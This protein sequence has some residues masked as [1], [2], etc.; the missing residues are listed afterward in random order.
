MSPP[1][2]PE[3]VLPRLRRRLTAVFALVAA[4]GLAAFVVVLVAADA[5]AERRRV[6][7]DL[8]GA[9]SRAAALVY[10]ED[11]DPRTDGVA[12][13][14][15][16][17]APRSVLVLAAAPGG[18]TRTLLSV[19][20]LDPAAVGG[21]VAAGLADAAEEGS[22]ASVRSA[23]RTLRAAAMPWFVGPQDGD[24]AERVAGVAVVAV[25]PP[26]VDAGRLLV[27]GLAGGLALLALLVAAGWTLAGRSLRPAQAALAD[28]E[29]F[30]A[31]AAHELR[32]PLARLRAGA[33]AA[34]RASAG[35]ADPASELRGLVRTADDAA[36]VVA[37]LLLAARIDHAAVVV[38]RQP[39]RLDELAGELELH[40]PQVVA[41]VTG[42]VTVTG[43]AGLLRHAL[44]NLVDNAV[45][46]GATDGRPPVVLVR[47]RAPGG[48]P[49]VEVGD[50]GPGLPPGL[51]VLRGWVTGPTGGTGLGL[52]LVAWIARRHGAAVRLGTGEDGRGARVMIA[53]PAPGRGRHRP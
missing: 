11:G 52:P 22:V 26:G 37:N 1:V 7:E 50:D 36:Q 16:V 14:M 29:R 5:A 46:H 19:G 20:G 28:R 23:G 21:L 53:F 31:T 9:A 10:L 43:D 24:A 25:P 34:S 8:R 32:T 48:A 33:E 18:G 4:L 41:D 27:P 6:D 12:D 44:R 13:D 49:T 40:A 47:V 42:P 35:G 39:V 15:V 2:R 45:R 17:E 30:L 38:G 51:D 3:L